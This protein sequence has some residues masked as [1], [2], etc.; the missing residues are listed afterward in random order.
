MRA[1]TRFG[2]ADLGEPELGSLCLAKM[3][4]VE[5]PLDLRSCLV[6]THAIEIQNEKLTLPHVL[7]I[8]ETLRSQRPLNG[9]SL[10]IEN[11]R[12]QHHPHMSFHRRDYTN[13]SAFAAPRKFS[14]NSRLSVGGRNA[15]LMLF[16]ASSSTLFLGNPSDSAS[17]Y[18]L[19]KSV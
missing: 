2:L 3:Q 17:E 18:S 4:A 5:P 16:S 7:N 19:S 13:P 10:R 9:L 11:R 14:S 15:A 8:G 6:A 12:F 1:A